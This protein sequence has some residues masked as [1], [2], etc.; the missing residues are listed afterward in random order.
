MYLSSIGSS[1]KQ[2][3]PQMP[4]QT[5]VSSI[6]HPQPSSRPIYMHV[7]SFTA[8]SSKP[9]TIASFANQYAC[10]S[11]CIFFREVVSSLSFSS[12]HILRDNSGHLLHLFA[13]MCPMVHFP[14]SC[15]PLT[16]YL[17]CLVITKPLKVVSLTSLHAHIP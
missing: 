9:L 10:F 1:S 16:A 6:D 7:S 13:Y 5:V 11:C 17:N 2:L 14:H 15:C 4:T 3:S 8:H 12:Y